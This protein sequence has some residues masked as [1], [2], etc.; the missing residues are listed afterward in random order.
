MNIKVSVLNNGD[1]A[2]KPNKMVLHLMSQ[3]GVILMTWPMVSGSANNDLIR[4]DRHVNIQQLIE[5]PEDAKILEVEI[6]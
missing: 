6:Q 5:P 3:D 2:A 1:T 4:R